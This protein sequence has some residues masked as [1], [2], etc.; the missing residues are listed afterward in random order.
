MKT[1]LRLAVE[2][3]EDGEVI[4]FEA[5]AQ[6]GGKKDMLMFLLAFVKGVQ[7]HVIEEADEMGIS[8]CEELKE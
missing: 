2:T 8:L 6:I 1:G 3:K 5:S 7:M 4:A